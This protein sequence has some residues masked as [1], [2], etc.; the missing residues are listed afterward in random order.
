MGRLLATLATILI[1]VLGAAFAVPAFVDWTAYRSGI[2]K[3]ASAILGR[4]VSILGDIDI[5]LLPEPHIRAASIAAGNGKADGALMTASAVDISL[6]LQAILGGRLEASKL[7]LVHPELT[8]DFTKPFSQPETAAMDGAFALSAEVKSIEIEAGR[9][10]VFSR[11]SAG[12]E[13]LALTKINGFVSASPP[14]GAYRFAGRLTQ[15]GHQYDVK[16]SAAPDSEKGV[17]LAGNAVDAASKIS[18]QA[19]GLLNAAEDPGFEGTMA[20][21]LPQGAGR[22]PFEIQLKSAAKIGFAEAALDDLSLTLDEQNRPQVFAGSAKLAFDAKTASIALQAHALDADTLASASAGQGTAMGAAASAEWS[23]LRSALGN[24]LW[25]YPEYAVS[26]AFEAGQIQLKG[27]PIE[28]VLIHGTRRPQR[29]IF[30]QAQAALPGGAS[31]KL[32][33]TLTGGSTPRLNATAALEGK[34][35]SRLSR[36]LIPP[37]P[38]GARAPAGAFAVQGSLTLSNEVSAF[39]G[40]SGSLEGTPFTASLHFEKAPVRKLQLALAGENF[41]LSSVESEQESAAALSPESFKEVWQGG[42]AQVAALLGG[43]PQGF[44]TADVDISAGG[45]KTSTAE[46]KNVAIHVKFDKDLI[47]V[48]KLSAETASGLVL[49]GEGAVP[50][51]GTGQGRFDGRLEARS[52]QAIVQLAGLAGARRGSFERRAADMAPAALSIG[53]SNDAA[54][55]TATALLSGN[56]GPARVECRAQLKGPLS[57]WRTD[58]LSTQ[59]KISEPDSNKLLSLLFPDA[60]FAPGASLSPGALAVSLNGVSEQLETSA[61]LTSGA[62]WVQLDGATDIKAQ[63]AGFKGKA[64]A[65]SLTPEQ[66]LPDS[67]LALL[68]GEP[69]ANLRLSANIAAAT[70]RFDADEL[71]AETQKNLV[72]GRLAIETRGGITRADANL[73]ADKASLPALLGYFLSGTPA[74]G[75]ALAVPAALGAPPPA[76]G[77]WSGRPF[78]MPAFQ[79][80]AGKIFLVA[81]TLKLSDALVLTDAQ[82]NANLDKGRLDIEDLRGRT[83]GGSFDASLSLTAKGATVSGEAEISLDG[84][85]LTELASPGTSPV[86]AGQASLSLLVSGQGLSP[87]GL[88][89]VLRGRGT[90]RLSGGTLAKMSPTAVQT[91]AEELLAEQLPLTEG[92]VT[93]KILAAIQTSDFAFRRLKIPVN[94]ADGI[95]EIRRAS[96]RG[97]EGTVRMEG[98]LDLNKAQVDSTWQMGVSSDSRHKWPP[99]KIM[100]SGPLRELGAR[101]K[102]LAGED[103][104]R[105]ILVRKMEGDI[106]RLE[107]LNRPNAQLPPA[108]PS[109]P[110]NKPSAAAPAW[111]AT[112]E[113]APQKSRRRK[114]EKVKSGETPAT[115]PP[116]ARSF[117]QRM[118]DALENGTSTPAAR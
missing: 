77:I 58:Q 101:P 51:R 48:S 72:T 83:L 20:L 63:S 62:L 8:L 106:N 117:E 25:L 42:L 13:A 103:F 115:Q 91:S 50:L 90:I 55:G 87:R 9:I 52:P 18:L 1:L 12:A 2:E 29:W 61:T 92:A 56:L 114:R 45:I 41:D 34:N 35:L 73:K 112:Q 54:T 98:Y 108:K 111:T 59:F 31:V 99:V 76:P 27:E 96:F 16:L 93:N 22:L 71:I 84:A 26:L 5:V 116:A 65:S 85:G 28:N 70:G 19:D 38:G 33:G 110:S 80:T 39:E 89:S 66:F 11:S 44:D 23:R 94:V 40:V 69:R 74:D 104:V 78:S 100:L 105:A 97:D 95:L 4:K 82:F 86:V 57:D 14:G 81:R 60:V 21:N 109:A 7:K 88:I 113:P 24:L 10:S 46:A 53:Y 49:R 6:S 102:F 68:G 107:S 67:L 79:E 15:N 47:T 30:E 17:K 36:W 37:G 64:S 3:T 118:R 75:A 32:A 43:D